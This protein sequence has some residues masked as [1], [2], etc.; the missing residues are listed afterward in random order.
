MRKE[1]DFEVMDHIRVFQAGNDK[2]KAIMERNFDEIKSEVL[3]EEITF[4]SVQ[5]YTKEWN[6]N[7]ED[8]IL[9]VEKN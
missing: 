3:A 5:G 7:G 2:I 1:A 4:G 8:V 9:G 6:L